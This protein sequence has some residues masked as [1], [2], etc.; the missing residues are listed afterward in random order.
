MRNLQQVDIIDILHKDHIFEKLSQTADKLQIET[1]LV[2]GYV[3]D[4]FLN[5]LMILMWLLSDQELSLQKV[6][7]TH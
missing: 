4:L 6:L 7:L 3:R 5:Q 1:Y 2:G